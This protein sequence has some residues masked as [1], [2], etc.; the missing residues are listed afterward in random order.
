MYVI[1]RNGTKVPF[2]KEKIIN[3]I[4]KAFLEIDKVLYETDTANDIAAE[5]EEYYLSNN[6]EIH[7]EDIQDYIEDL[8]MESE[9]KDVARAYIRFRYKREVAREQKDIFFKAVSEK[10]EAKNVKN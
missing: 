10:L 2:N 1:K 7:V 3:A 5:I 9:R 8:L 4:N 6:L